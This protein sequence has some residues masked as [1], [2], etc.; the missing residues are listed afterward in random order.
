M[1]SF[2]QSK[3]S[4]RSSRSF[5]HCYNPDPFCRIISSTNPH[6]PDPLSPDLLSSNP[7]VWIR[8]DQ[9]RPIR[10]RFDRIRFDRILIVR[11]CF[12]FHHQELLFRTGSFRQW[13]RILRPSNRGRCSRR[14]RRSVSDPPSRSVGRL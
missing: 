10:I 2:N 11:I 1:G 7:L 5:S 6:G 12:S 13:D 4:K 9:I 3:V 8:L 14:R